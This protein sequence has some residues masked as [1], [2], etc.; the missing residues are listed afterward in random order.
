MSRVTVYTTEPCS[1]CRNAQGAARVA[2][3]RVHGDQSLKGPGRTGA[4]SPQRTGMLSFPQ[5]VVDDAPLGGF[6]ELLEADRDGTPG[7]PARGLTP[8]QRRAPRLRLAA[9]A[10]VGPPPRRPQLDHRRRRTP[11]T[12]RPPRRWTRKASWKEPDTPSGSRKSSI[13]APLAS[14]PASSAATTASRSA[15]AWARVM[16]PAGRS[17]WMRAREQRLVGVDVPHAR[18]PALV[19]QE[20]LDRRAAAR[21]T[22]R[23][24]CSAVNASPS[25]STPSRAAKKASSASPPSA[26]SPVPKRRGSTKSSVRAVVEAQA[27]ARVRRAARA[28]RRAACRSCAGA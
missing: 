22:A 27:H 11:G 16:R 5:I 10:H 3:R 7:S 6:R 14:I 1:F 19:E 18:D 9:R 24:R 8:P 25:G 21:A 4:S 17:G 12:A 28:R 13:V 15:A 23:S 26:S 20:R 2:R